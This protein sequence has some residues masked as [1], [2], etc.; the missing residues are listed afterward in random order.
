MRC[1]TGESQDDDRDGKLS[2]YQPEHDLAVAP[3]SWE[4]EMHVG[5]LGNGGQLAPSGFPKGGFSRETKG[6]STS[7]STR[8]AG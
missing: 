3:F 7:E 1:D 4:E 8:P 5:W 2:D 6:Y